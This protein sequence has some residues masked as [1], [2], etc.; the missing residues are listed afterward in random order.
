[1]FYERDYAAAMAT[2]AASLSAGSQVGPLVAGY[3]INAAGWR[4]F[5][6]LSAIMLAVN[7][8]AIVFLLPETIHES[9]NEITTNEANES[10]KIEEERLE[11]LPTTTSSQ[12][13]HRE[14]FN[15]KQHFADLFKF[16]LT[17]AARE[18]GLL[19]HFAY[20]FVLPLPLLMVPG[21]IVASLTFGAVLG[22]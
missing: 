7:I 18:R 1:M 2:F 5:F 22:G 6:I 11:R 3:L 12:V 20:L 17:K 14:T 13:I 21:A 4:W 19:K 9:D 16:G 15:Y 10:G 8:V